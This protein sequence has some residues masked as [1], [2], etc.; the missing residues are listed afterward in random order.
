MTNHKYF[1]RLK[2]NAKELEKITDKNKRG[3]MMYYFALY[4]E[5]RNHPEVSADYYNKITKMQTPM[6]FEYRLA[7]WALQQ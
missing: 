7:E 1:P 6:F 4:F 2:C 3:K 5:M